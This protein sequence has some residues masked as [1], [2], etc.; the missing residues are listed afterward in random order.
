MWLPRKA[1]LC[2]GLRSTCGC[3]NSNAPSGLLPRLR[4]A[5]HAP[6]RSCRAHALCANTTGRLSAYKN[7]SRDQASCCGAMPSSADSSKAMR[8]RPLRTGCTAKLLQCCWMRCVSEPQSCNH[9]AMPASQFT[10]APCQY[11]S[12]MQIVMF[13]GHPALQMR[14]RGAGEIAQQFIGCQPRVIQ[15]IL[16]RADV[17]EAQ[18]R[19]TAL[20]CADQFARPAQF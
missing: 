1:L 11:W 8:A 20:A 18:H 17:G 13:V 16:I 9:G 7:T 2:S 10:A 4:T 3:A 12:D 6:R 15:Q 14:L 5:D 19:Y